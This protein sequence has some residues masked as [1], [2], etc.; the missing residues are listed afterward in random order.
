[1]SQT[2]RSSDEQF[3]VCSLQVVFCKPVEA[4]APGH[5]VQCFSASHIALIVQKLLSAV[6][7]AN[8]V[9]ADAENVLRHD[10]G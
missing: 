4:N 9:A 2:H 10:E 3:E 8:V 7:A 1:M 5:T 6:K